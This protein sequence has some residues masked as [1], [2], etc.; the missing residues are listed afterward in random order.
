[1]KTL[2]EQA[3]IYAGILDDRLDEELEQMDDDALNKLSME[4]L[5][6]DFWLYALMLSTEIISHPVITKRERIFL[7]YL[8]VLGNNKEFEELLHEE[9][10][11]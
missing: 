8:F 3:R 1:M 4:D 7:N 6:R 11:A 10:F 9:E 2:I 5:L